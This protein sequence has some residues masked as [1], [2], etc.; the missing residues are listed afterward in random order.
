M[1]RVVVVGML[2]VS[3]LMFAEGNFF[4]EVEMPIYSSKT[5][6]FQG[7]DLL[8]IHAEG[9]ETFTSANLDGEYSYL[10]QGK[11][12]SY[13]FNEALSLSVKGANWEDSKYNSSSN[14]S[15]G[16]AKYFEKDGKQFQI[17]GNTNLLITSSE[18][19]PI[20]VNFGAGVGRIINVTPYTK[21]IYIVKELEVN[22]DKAMLQN[23]VKIINQEASY[24]NEFDFYKDIAKVI[25]KPN[26]AMS[27]LPFFDKTAVLISEKTKGW[28]ILGAI[29]NADVLGNPLPDSNFELKGEYAKPIGINRQFIGYVLFNTAGENGSMKVGGKYTVDHTLSW[30]SFADINIE[31]VFVEE[32]NGKSYVVEFGTQKAIWNKLTS[33][34]MLSGEKDG[35][36]DMALDFSV[37]FKYTLF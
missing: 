35:D 36:E 28:Q 19:P 10:N 14:L 6:S 37:N 3:C 8:N 13:Y 30:S 15:A 11:T 31:N 12:L 32:G 9:G 26:E 27:V 1:K 23:I 5:L 24:K 29:N 34:I 22:Y 2:L 18:R 17:F 20:P 33:E 7:N 16:M 21:A 25:G 4:D